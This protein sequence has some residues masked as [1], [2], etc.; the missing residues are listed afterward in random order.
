MGMQHSDWSDRRHSSRWQAET[1]D[2]GFWVPDRSE[3]VT[4]F[5]TRYLFFSLAVIYFST[6]DS[7]PPVLLSIEQLLMALCVYFILNTWFFR[8][9][10]KGVSLL[11]IRSAMIADLVIVTLCV[12]LKKKVRYCHTRIVKS[13]SVWLAVV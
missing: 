9:A 8:Q 11:K 1:E 2:A 10:L 6:L 3:I 4:Q 7:V 13:I 12:I 5:F